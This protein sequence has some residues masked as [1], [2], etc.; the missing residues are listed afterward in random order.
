MVK[1]LLTP[2]CAKKCRFS[3]LLKQADFYAFCVKRIWTSL[4]SLIEKINT[5]FLAVCNQRIIVVSRYFWGFRIWTYF[6]RRHIQTTSW[7]VIKVAGRRR[8]ALKLFK[9]RWS[10][11]ATRSGYHLLGWSKPS[12][13]KYGGDDDGAELFSKLGV[14][15]L[16]TKS[17]IGEKLQHCNGSVGNAA[18]A[19]ATAP[20][21]AAAAAAPAAANP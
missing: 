21:A 19:A 6:Q 7:V 11:T 15:L 3:G 12:T 17:N 16:G 5:L 9:R 20:A 2:K 13:S 10:A 14:D 8:L 1:L 18:A 4:F